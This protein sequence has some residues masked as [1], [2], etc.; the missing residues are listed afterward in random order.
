MHS[1]HVLISTPLKTSDEVP[2]VGEP[3]ANAALPHRGVQGHR[4]TAFGSFKHLQTLPSWRGL[5]PYVP[6][7]DVARD[8]FPKPASDTL[9]S[10]VIVND[11]DFLA[12][13]LAYALHILGSIQSSVETGSSI[14][15]LLSVNTTIGSFLCGS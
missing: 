8:V 1:A 6:L 12:T 9:R 7:P 11:G 4:N 13:Y 5:I 3:I 14:F 15:G 2:K 10:L